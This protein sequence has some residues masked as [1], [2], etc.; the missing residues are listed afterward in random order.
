MFNSERGFIF[1][2]ILPKQ[3]AY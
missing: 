3:Y 2:L 1:Y